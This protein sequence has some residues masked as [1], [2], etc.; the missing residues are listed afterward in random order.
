MEDR[1][2]FSPDPIA[3]TSTSPLAGQ[4]RQR[5]R[6]SPPEESPVASTSDFTS[7]FAGPAIAAETSPSNKGKRKAFG[8]DVDLSVDNDLAVKLDSELEELDAAG[9]TLS[10]F[11]LE[12]IE[13]YGSTPT[14]NEAE[15]VDA[16]KPEPAQQELPTLPAREPSQAKAQPLAEYTCP[17]CFSPPTAA[18]ALVCGHLFC[19]EC[20]FSAVKTSIKRGLTA[21]TIDSALARCVKFRLTNV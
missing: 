6:D 20:L 13:N 15:L 16:S 11:D 8:L 1:A 12:V 7:G 19:G 14:K 17:I 9:P 4:K 5:P 10:S 21:P 18:A 3:L 2:S